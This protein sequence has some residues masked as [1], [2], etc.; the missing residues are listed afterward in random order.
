MKKGIQSTF[1]AAVLTVISVSVM[2]QSSAVTNAHF[3]LQEAREY[4][5]N[6]DIDKAV[7]KMETAR[8]NIDK[9]VENEK[10]STKA[11]TWNYRGDIY[12][13]MLSLPEDKIGMTYLEAA[14]IS[15]ESYNKTIELDDSKR[16]DYKGP[17]QNGKNGIYPM[18]FNQGIEYINKE[19]YD[20]AMDAFDVVL[21]INPLDTNAALNAGLAAE[22]KPDMERAVQYYGMMIYQ[23]GAKDYYPFVRMAAYYSEKEEYDKA[24]EVISKGI[25][26]TSNKDAIK[27]L[28]TTEFNIYLKSGRLEEAM[29]NLKKSIEEDPDNDGNY[30]RLG[31]L[32]D[33]SGNSEEALKYYSLAL[34]KNPDNIDANYNLGAFYFNRGAEA[35]QSTRDMDL[36]TYKEKGKAIEDQAIEDLQK[37]KPYFEKVDSLQPNDPAVTTSLESINNILKSAGK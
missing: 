13:E 34:E 8:D 14:K 27:D 6:G 32:Y 30:S 5:A 26:S 29:A 15:I 11:K 36:N 24:L 21:Q 22:R 17:A 9:A 33:Q 23:Q 10:T 37:A 28:Q 16:G 18:M 2:A 1:F 35:L 31:Q 12:K 20:N 19:D 4:M 7:S 25:A 3:A